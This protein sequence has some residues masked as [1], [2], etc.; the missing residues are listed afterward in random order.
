MKIRKKST[1]AKIILF[2]L[3][4]V[5]IFLVVRKYFIHPSISKSLY[6]IDGS[7]A[8]SG[9]WIYDIQKLTSKQ[10]L[11]FASLLN[12]A[13]QLD[14]ERVMYGTPVLS[15]DGKNVAFYL[16][17]DCANRE[18]NKF[19][20]LW[21]YNLTKNQTRKLLE[22]IDLEPGYIQGL[23]WADNKNFYANILEDNQQKGI[24]Y[25]IN[26]NGAKKEII[27][28]KPPNIFWPQYL[29]N[30][31]IIYDS[32][33]PN[34]FKVSLT[35]SKSGQSGSIQT[36]T[37]SYSS[38]IFYLNRDTLVKV[39]FAYL[40]YAEIKGKDRIYG[41]ELLDL[42]TFHPIIVNL[43]SDIQ[44]TEVDYRVQP[45]VYCKNHWSIL[46]VVGKL[47]DS[48]DAHTRYYT[49][50]LST[51]AAKQITL[52]KN[53]RTYFRCS[54]GS[55]PE[56]YAETENNNVILI[57]F[58]KNEV[59]TLN[60]LNFFG[61]NY[62]DECYTPMLGRIGYISLKE[63]DL[64]VTFALKYTTSTEPC[65]SS[66]DLSGLYQFNLKTNKIIKVAPTSNILGF[67]N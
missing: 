60:L 54:E 62:Q 10:L 52:P 61:P 42:K 13:G 63:N 23:N 29:A 47:S 51:K 31:W 59:K 36:Q 22:C 34:S 27:S 55:K 21:N 28:T 66:N 50:N 4:L 65:L 14:S 67:V 20:N 5:L 17:A 37:T 6:Y 49:Y 44:L 30:N 33:R 53:I 16:M 64:F 7:G 39:D 15:P 46:G 45:I 48:W 35:N 3:V 8:D 41:L 25:K 38:N 19:Y 12:N 18:S 11:S 1:F 40:S 9:L 2:A 58:E 24:I 32:G 43:P 57:D 26:I 56:A